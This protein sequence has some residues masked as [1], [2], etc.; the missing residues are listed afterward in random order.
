MKEPKLSFAYVH[1]INQIW[2]L[3]TW[4]K[5]LCK[6]SGIPFH[7]YVNFNVDSVREFFFLI[8]C[9]VQLL[10]LHSNSVIPESALLH[11]KSKFKRKKKKKEKN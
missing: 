11:G 9:S 4:F 7:F 2:I 1:V 3:L 8:I 5:C 6:G 10:P